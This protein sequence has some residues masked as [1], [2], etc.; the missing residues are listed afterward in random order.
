L[1][2][3]ICIQHEY[4]AM[5]WDQS[6][7][8][9][10][11]AIYQYSG[12]AAKDR[13]RLIAI[14]TQCFGPDVGGI[15]ALMTGLAD[16]LSAAGWPIRVFADRVHAQGSAELRRPY[17]IR[18]FA[19]I[20]PLRSLTKRRAIEQAAKS[21]AFT[22]L[23]ADSWK[24]VAAAPAALGPIAAFA[25]GTE[26][27]PDAT[28][29]KARRIR[30]ALG[31]CKS[32]IA[33]S[34]Y[35]AALARPYVDGAAVEIVVINPPVAELP[36]AEPAALAGIDAII[37][38]RG[39]VISTLARLEP[40]KGVDA[41]IRALPELR[42]RHPRLVYIVAGAG[43]D[44]ERLERLAVQSGVA[45]CV[46]FPGEITDVQAKAALLTRSDVYAMPSRRVGHSV[47]GFGIAYVEAAWYGAPSVA[48]N[49][50]G[51]GDAVIDGRTGLLC[52]G[53]D[54][55]AVLAALSRLV[56]DE[57]LRKGYGA[58]AAHFARAQHT[59]RAALPRYLQAIG[60]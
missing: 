51:A 46:V 32:I 28:P 34:H 3:Q 12:R 39:P 53:A 20:R 1:L 31:R 30:A 54:D 17:P 59:W 37:A 27:P 44:R 19:A 29:D 15:E 47:E 49:D 23:F 5:R 48:G 18:R 35:T 40:R 52:A 11:G 45:A 50:G 36:A 25:H 60:L 4:I 9:R 22:G 38:G 41:V 55:S 57:P 33:S 43:A 13:T 42:V 8:N 14:A 58:A 6:L 24:S 10:R 56:D 7:L 16:H 2:A 21:E 26:F